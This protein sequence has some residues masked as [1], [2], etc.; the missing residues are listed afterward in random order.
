[1]IKEATEKK[2]N[3][4]CGKNKKEGYINCDISK[5]VNPDKIINLEKTPLPFKDN[6]IDEVLTHH[7][8]EHIN[9]LVPLMHEIHRICKEKAMIKI[10][11]PFYLSVGAF[12][13]P[14][15]KR[16]FTPFTMDYFCNSPYNYET[17]KQPLFNLK[18]VE[19]RYTFTR[20]INR[21]INPIINL[22]HKVY[23]KF[24]AGIFP[25][26]EIYYE[27]EVLK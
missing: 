7:T 26:S 10:S 24:F 21:L 3:L 2:L 14:T 4:G 19:L 13:D 20:K 25:C 18:K 6:S 8:L 17:G 16:F 15:H 1:M 9:N 22:N 23:C 5:E 11:V 12:M 27:L